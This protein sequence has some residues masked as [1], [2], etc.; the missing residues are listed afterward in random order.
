MTAEEE[1]EEGTRTD[2]VSRLWNSSEFID[3]SARNREQIHMK[4]WSF[5]FLV[6]Q[7]NWWGL[8]FYGKLYRGA[9]AVSCLFISHTCVCNLHVY[10]ICTQ[11]PKNVIREMLPVLCLFSIIL[12][13]VLEKNQPSFADQSDA[14]VTSTH[15]YC[16]TFHR[17]AP[18]WSASFVCTL[19]A[20][21]GHLSVLNILCSWHLWQTYSLL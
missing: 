10:L 6:Y 12:Y 20:E 7:S 8:F 1:E 16:Y 21:E 13:I 5:L 19:K 17:S 9:L 3:L 11:G 18:D 2:F 4:A 14:L 15:V